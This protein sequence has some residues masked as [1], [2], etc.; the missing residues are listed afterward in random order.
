MATDE[1]IR[2]AL[3]QVVDPEINLSIIDLGLVREIDQS[4][5]PNVV[6]MLLT[7]PFCPFAPQII[8][9]VKEVMTTV[10]GK[11]AEV[12][13]LAEQ[14]TPEMMPDPGLLGRW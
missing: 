5:D 9:Q 12:E 6:R 3:E 11:S 14:W 1:E 4:V 7:T 10:T 8:A 2:T 13:I